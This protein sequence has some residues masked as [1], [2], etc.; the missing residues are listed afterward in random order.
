MSSAQRRTDGTL[1]KS[2]CVWVP[3]RQYVPSNG[4][5]IRKTDIQLHRDIIDELTWQPSVNEAEI[6]VSVKG[7]VVALLGSVDSYARKFAAERVAERVSG[8]RAIADD[9]Q[10]RVPGT[11]QRSDTEIAHAALNAQSGTSRCPRRRSR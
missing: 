10:V 2:E 5:V 11:L 4:G 7:G 3:A 6:A 1:A 8:V 9:L